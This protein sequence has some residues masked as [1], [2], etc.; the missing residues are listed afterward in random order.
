MNL[1]PYDNIERRYRHTDIPNAE[2]LAVAARLLQ[3]PEP[4]SGD[5]VFYD[6]SFFSGGIGVLDRLAISLPASPENCGRIL[7]SP[8]GQKRLKN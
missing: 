4:L 5:E 3:L 7:A 1:H 2:G 8:C 6:L